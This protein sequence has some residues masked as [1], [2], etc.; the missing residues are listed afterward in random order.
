MNQEKSSWIAGGHA[1]LWLTLGNS[2]GLWLAILQLF[3]ALAD[4]NALPSYG[5]W[6][7]VHLNLQLYGWTS[8]PLIAW[9]FHLYQVREKWANVSCAAWSMALA[10]GVIAW[11]GG[12]TS[13]KIFLDWKGGAFFGFLLAQVIL[14]CVLF[15][16]WWRGKRSVWLGLGLLVLAAI[17]LSFVMATSPKTYPPIDPTTGGP[18]GASLLGSTLSVVALMILFPVSLGWRM[19][20][21][22]HGLWILWVVEFFA[23]IAL[24]TIGGTHYTWHQILGLALL[25]PWMVMIPRYWSQFDWPIGTRGWRIACLVWW[26]LLV[27]SGWIEF[28]PNVLDRMKFTNGLVGHAHWAMAGFTSSY[29]CLLLILLNGAKATI[30]IKR[31]KLLWNLAAFSMGLVLIICGWQEGDDYA[32]MGESPAWRWSMLCVRAICGVV[33]LIVSTSWCWRWHRSHT[34]SS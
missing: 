19:T 15:L 8:F 23:F 6:M 12:I 18:T 20:S 28:L 7:P 31:G 5:R 21:K 32:W 33:L 16:S 27:V 30:I 22:W 14:W 29:V 11:L 13:G 24:E 10:C 25:M 26:A 2:V 17:P 9:L 4:G 34:I 1:L 3:P